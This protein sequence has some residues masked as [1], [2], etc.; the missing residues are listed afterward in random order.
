MLKNITTLAAAA[1]LGLSLT[2]CGETDE[3][4]EEEVEEAGAEMEAAG[5][6]LEDAMEDAGDDIDAMADDA[7]DG[8]EEMAD[9]VE[10]EVDPD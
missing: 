7:E 5:D 2:A 6:D 4:I 9:D 8:M 1:V 3:P 10:N